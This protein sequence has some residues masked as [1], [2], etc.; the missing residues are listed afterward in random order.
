MGVWKVRSCFLYPYGAGYSF[1][2]DCKTNI[3]TAQDGERKTDEDRAE[4]VRKPDV[5]TKRFI[6]ESTLSGK[7]HRF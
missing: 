6:K 1:H 7:S 3:N 4:P 5:H 2:T